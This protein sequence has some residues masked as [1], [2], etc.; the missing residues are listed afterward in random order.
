M[1]IIKNNTG[2]TLLYASDTWIGKTANLMETE[3]EPPT[4]EECQAARLLK[5]GTTPE[6]FRESRNPKRI[7]KRCLGEPFRP[8]VLNALHDVAILAEA[9]YR[10]GVEMPQEIKKILEINGLFGYGSCCPWS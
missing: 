3:I 6:F 2:K 1:G 7:P 5:K 10:A 9:H 8:D 4:F